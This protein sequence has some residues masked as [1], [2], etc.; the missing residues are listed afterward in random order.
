MKILV[1]AASR[2]DATAEIATAIAAVLRGRGHQVEEM[3]PDNVHDVSQYDAVVIG[4]AVYVGR[5][6]EAARSLVA[7]FAT[8]L[9]E[10]PVW[11]F[12]SGPLGDPPKPA[13]DP[14]VSALIEATRAV[15]HRVFTGKLDKSSLGPVE[16][17]VA[18]AVRAPEGD[19]R[20]W[21]AINEWAENI[22]EAVLDR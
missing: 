2:H 22:A 3:A 4:S 12:S 17:T 6:L 16:R 5:W 8:H 18:R 11:L 10:R 20:D 9:A 21:D 7:R 15:E 13:E 14:D 1:T 19:Y